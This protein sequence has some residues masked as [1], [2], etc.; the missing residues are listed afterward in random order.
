MTGVTGYIGGDALYQIATKHPDYDISA[1]V[2]DSDKGAQV[3][4]QYPKIRLVYGT[5]DDSKTLEEEAAKADVVLN[6]ASADHEAGAKAL[7]QGLASKGT[8]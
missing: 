6:F 1:L 5:L 7:V 4:S 2:R 3:A 8:E